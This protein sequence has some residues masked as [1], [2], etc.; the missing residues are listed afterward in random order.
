MS[1]QIGSAQRIMLPWVTRL[2]HSHFLTWY[3]DPKKALG[4]KNK[5][6]LLWHAKGTKGLLAKAGFRTTQ[7][8]LIDWFEE[9][10]VVVTDT[11]AIIERPAGKICIYAHKGRIVCYP[12]PDLVV[13]VKTGTLVK[14]KEYFIPTNDQGNM[15]CVL[16]DSKANLMIS[17]EAIDLI[18]TIERGRDAVGD[19]DW[20]KVDDGT[21]VFCWRG[22]IYRIVDPETCVGARG[23]STFP[24]ECEIIKND[25]PKEIVE[26]FEH[27]DYSPNHASWRS[28]HNV[29]KRQVAS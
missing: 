10:Y 5:A 17:Q 14:P 25:V 1:F 18:D 29:L 20:F 9:G 13:Y 4:L 11:E 2:T 27:R 12:D 8:E 24:S 22:P 21:Y 28:P 23:L 19:T 16:C 3:K 6:D 7:K 15:G 26:A